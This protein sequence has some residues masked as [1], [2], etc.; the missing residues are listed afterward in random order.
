MKVSWD[1]LFFPTEWKKCS[2]PPTSHGVYHILPLPTKVS[3]NLPKT[4][5]HDNQHAML[6]LSSTNPKYGLEKYSLVI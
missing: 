1:Y 4:Q 6:I 2:K 5:S 3:C